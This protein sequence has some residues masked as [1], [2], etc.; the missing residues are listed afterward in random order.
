MSDIVAALPNADSIWTAILRSQNSIAD[1]GTG[2]VEYIG[3][4]TTI[5][6]VDNW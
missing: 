3:P 6:F 1:S 4:A 2:A 5:A